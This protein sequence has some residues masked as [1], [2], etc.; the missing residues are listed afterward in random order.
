[1]G[2]QKYL[3]GLDLKL[4]S[5][6]EEKVIIFVVEELVLELLRGY[7]HFQIFRQR[8]W[9]IL[10]YTNQNLSSFRFSR[11]TFLIFLQQ[12]LKRFFEKLFADPLRVSI[13]FLV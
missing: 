9:H 1:M 7:V 11:P 4:L 6:F 5:N 12:A 2:P 3:L 13:V 10:S 8:I